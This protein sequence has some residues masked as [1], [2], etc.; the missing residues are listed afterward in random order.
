MNAFDFTKYAY[1]DK[2]NLHLRKNISKF[3]MSILTEC[4]GTDVVKAKGKSRKAS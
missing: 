1:T 4:E 3:D 2:W